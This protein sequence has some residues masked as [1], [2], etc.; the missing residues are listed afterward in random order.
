[1]AEPRPSERIKAALWRRAFA[2]WAGTRA[3][4]TEGYTL[5]LPVPADLPVFLRLALAGAASQDAQERVE[6]LVVPDA[7]SREFRAE[8]EA[9]LGSVDVP[10]AR[11][12]EPRRAAQVMRRA[13]GNAISSNH[14]IQLQAGLDS[15][16][17]THAL[18]HDADLFI[19]DA[20]FLDRHYRR[21]LDGG[22][23]CLGVAPA[24]DDWL[25]E[26]G[27]GH[28]AATW[29]LMVTTEWA[30]SFPPWQH[31]P[32]ADSLTGERHVFDTMLYTQALTA[33]E[34][35]GLHDPGDAFVHFN[36][37]IG[38]YRNFERASGPFEDDRFLLVLIRF[39]SE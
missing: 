18:L 15:A 25:R 26:H 24:W 1:M 6:T 21:A 4:K 13:A 36:W 31:R 12:V 35:C 2:H 11:L 14:F 37:V 20:G 19:R 10:D 32:R 29:E 16:R 33:P 28:V 5:L 7:P 3:P 22:F 23:A 30:Y 9:A 38:V 17:A 39:L 27:H 34:R 8:L